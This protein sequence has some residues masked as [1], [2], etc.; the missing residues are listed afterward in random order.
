MNVRPDMDK[1]LAWL[2]ATRGGLEGLSPE[3]ARRIWSALS[4]EARAVYLATLPSEPTA[5]TKRGGS[6]KPV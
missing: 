2:H 4:P 5:T 3:G 6:E 1:L